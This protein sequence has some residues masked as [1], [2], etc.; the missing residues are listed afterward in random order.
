[1][2]H[3]LEREQV[4][5]APPA[6]LFGFFAEARNLEKLAPPWLRFEVLTPD[7][8]E[9]R[10]GAVIEYRLR[11]RGLPMRWASLIEEWQ[12]GRRFVD[13]QVRGPYRFWHHTHDFEKHLDGTL[14]RDTVRY[15]LPLGPLGSLAHTAFVRR[16]LARVFDYRHE[17]V[18]ALWHANTRAGE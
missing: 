11:L 13:R 10:A 2:S 3:L 9:M 6:Q 18:A 7:P 1:M 4:V 12:P 15:E 5:R 16:D 8:I 14:I 17:Q